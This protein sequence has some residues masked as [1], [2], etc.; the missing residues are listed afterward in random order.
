MFLL[1]WVPSVQQRYRLQSTNITVLSLE[2]SLESSS[3]HLAW[4]S[5]WQ[6][7]R[8]REQCQAKQGQDKWGVV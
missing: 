8:E 2:Y 6:M 3:V 1:L 5:A 4:E 7:N